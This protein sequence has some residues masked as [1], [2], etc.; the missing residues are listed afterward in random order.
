[1][2][3]KGGCLKALCPICTQSD[4]LSNAHLNQDRRK[5]SHNNDLEPHVPLRALSSAGL[6]HL[7]YKQGVGGSNPSA[8]TLVSANENGG[9]SLLS[10]RSAGFHPRF[11]FLWPLS[12]GPRVAL[13]LNRSLVTAVGHEGQSA[14]VDRNKEVIKPKI[15]RMRGEHPVQ[16]FHDPRFPTV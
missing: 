3:G 6:E 7:P 2:L 13:K 16:L 5:D 10:Y 9:E 15:G 12:V 1:M 4:D 11:W 14:R 8:P